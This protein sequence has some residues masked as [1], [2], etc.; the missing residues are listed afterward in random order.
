MDDSRTVYASDAHPN[1]GVLLRFVAD[2]PGDLSSG[3]LY[4]AKFGAQK[5]DARGAATWTVSWVELGRATQSELERLVASGL[6]FSDIFESAPPVGSPPACPPGFQGAATPSPFFRAADP[7]TFAAYALECL[8]ARPGMETAAAFLET[9]RWAGMRGATAEFERMDGLAHSRRFRQLYVAVGRVAHGMTTGDAQFGA[10]S[11][12]IRL[13]P[14]DCGALFSL[15]LDETRA[16]YRARVMLVG[17]QQQ[18]QQQQDTPPAG[19][20]SGSGS[21][22]GGPGAAAGRCSPSNVADPER[23]AYLGGNLVVQEAAGSGAGRERAAMWAY[24]VEDGRLTRLLTGPKGATL[25][26]L[27]TMRLGANAYLTFAVQPAPS[28]SLSTATARAGSSSSSGSS[29]DIA[30][31]DDDEEEARAGVPPL[32]QATSEE[33]LLARRGAVGYLGPFPGDLLSDEWTLRFDAAPEAGDAE[34]LASPRVCATPA[35]RGAPALQP[36]AANVAGGAGAGAAA[37]G[38]I[39]ATTAAADGARDTAASS[40]GS[41]GTS[42]H[43]G[44][45]GGTMAATSAGANSNATTPAAPPAPPAPSALGNSSSNSS[46]G[47]GGG[48]AALNSRRMQLGH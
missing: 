15:D 34:V 47:G 36:S 45:N 13:P 11:D 9:R 30:A 43:G 46:A 4:A 40:G 44:G 28:P 33:E 24:G 25:T 17:R 16:A 48:G 27:G 29:F 1:G 12:D 19:G 8:R 20:S 35:A 6:K 41:S 7:A 38:A 5:P 18:Q 32:S 21:G 39:S 37:F 22:S 23:T 26:G 3:V 31:G 14:N 42:D 10:V 2:R